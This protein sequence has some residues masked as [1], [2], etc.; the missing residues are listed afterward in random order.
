MNSAAPVGGGAMLQ[1]DI[2]MIEIYRQPLTGHGF[3]SDFMQASW[4][5]LFAKEDI[6]VQTEKRR[7]H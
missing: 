5:L 2:E 4:S 6:K 7:R 3:Q 1:Y